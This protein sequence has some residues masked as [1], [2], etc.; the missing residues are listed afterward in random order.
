MRSGI[1]SFSFLLLE[2]LCEIQSRCLREDETVKL[3]VTLRAREIALLRE[4]AAQDTG[5]QALPGSEYALNVC[6]DHGKLRLM[7]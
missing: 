5:P 2:R 1:K 4:T 6:Y 7:Y 3:A